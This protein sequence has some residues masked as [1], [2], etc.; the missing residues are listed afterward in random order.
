MGLEVVELPAST[1]S[2]K[3]AAFAIGCKVD[4]IAKSIVFR[5]T[6]SDRAVMVVVRGSHRV[7]EGQVATAVGEAIEKA[8]PDFVREATGYA[9]GGVPPCGHLHPV[10]VLL[11]EGLRDFE[12]LW[13][14]AGTP[15]AVF[16]LTPEQLVELTG[17]R[18]LDVVVR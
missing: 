18:L 1:R 13:A 11:D 3:E 7:D 5:A 9:I 16:S 4:Q 17:G 10:L 12:A 2:A 14:A 8:T 15:N 6:E